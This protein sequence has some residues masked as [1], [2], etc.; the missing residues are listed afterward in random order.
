MSKHA[1]AAFTLDSWDQES[2][3]EQAGGSIGQ[4]AVTKTYSGEL[5]GTSVTRLLFGAGTED[6]PG[7][8]GFE[9]VTADL[10]GRKGTFMLHHNAARVG[11]DPDKGFFS[12]TVLAN[13]GTGDLTG[14]SGSAQITVAADGGHTLDLD[15][16]I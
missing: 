6:S 3:V 14:I 4:A 11:D 9:I 13:S 10:Q 12:L 5:T 15:Y 7:Y 1:T 16:T 2:V 8:A